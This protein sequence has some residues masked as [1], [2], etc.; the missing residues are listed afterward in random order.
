MK[1]RFSI[2][3]F[4]A[5]SLLGEIL[6]WLMGLLLFLWVL[7]VL[8]TYQ[9]ATNIAD[10]PYDQE[11]ARDIS[12]LASHVR[13]ADGEIR[14]DLGKD[15]LEWM[16][17]ASADRFYL[18]VLGPRGELLFGD[19]KMPWVDPSDVGDSGALRYR[20]DTI[21][22]EELRVAYE[23]VPMSPSG[24]TV[25]L[26][27]GETRK[28][29]KDLAKAMV[30]GII[31][32]QF[33]IVPVAVLLVYLALTRGITPLQRLQEELR[34]RR[35]SNLTPISVEGIPEEIRPLIEALN[36]VMLRLDSTLGAQRQF[37]ADAAHQLK[38]PLAGLRSQVDLMRNET[39]PAVLASGLRHVAQGADNMAR[40]VQQLLSLARAESVADQ[41]PSFAPVDLDHLA[42]EVT[43]ECAEKALAKR[44]DLGFE[45]AA[46]AATIAG[47]PLLLHEM[48]LNL[49][50]NAIKYTPPG[51]RV[52]VRVFGADSPALEVEDSGVGLPPDERA[53][54]FSR[55]YRV[56][57]RESEGSGLG[58]AIVKEI[59]DLH[60]A[61]IT[62]DDG[63][64]GT[65]LR[66]RVSFS[67][68]TAGRL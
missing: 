63:S 37:I 35:P 64:D 10:R 58:L 60:A 19:A 62:I 1:L 44:I 67:S 51:G 43:V 36:G 56:L 28:R 16:R 21:D 54:V 39:D 53:K 42:R 57:G 32:P 22:G 8:T 5:K 4:A 29:R 33:I 27:V 61:R 47:M 9:V 68:P 13:L 34:R 41:G 55:F 59:A 23:L 26:Q 20:D 18:Q 15:E 12:V 3:R 66:A 40:L 48:L 7:S 24:P 25:L 46:V 65:G 30:Q 38:T 2:L 50:D 14:I 49:V 52:T 17:T 6:L 31:V 11:L 45:P